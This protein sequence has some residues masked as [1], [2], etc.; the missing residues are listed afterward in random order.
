MT[1]LG[2]R[3]GRTKVQCC[4][5]CGDRAVRPFLPSNRCAGQVNSPASGRHKISERELSIASLQLE[6][7]IYRYRTP[8]G[9]VWSE[10]GM[11]SVRGGDIRRTRRPVRG[12]GQVP[13][14]CPERACDVTGPRDARDHDGRHAGNGRVDVEPVPPES[15][16]AGRPPPAHAV[17]GAGMDLEVRRLGRRGAGS[18]GPSAGGT[19]GRRNRQAHLRTGSRKR[20]GT[21]G[22][23]EQREGRRSGWPGRPGSSDR[24]GQRRA[25]SRTRALSS[26]TW[27]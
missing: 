27:S 22:R 20:A 21:P 4:R 18:S 8:G 23:A 9:A 6:R 7:S 26:C 5:A 15:T 10:Q 13:V 14:S 24:T 11:T 19:T 12:G 16:A 1:P 17:A 25:R 3:Q 2:G